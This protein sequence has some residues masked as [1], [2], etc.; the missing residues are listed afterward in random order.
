MWIYTLSPRKRL[1]RMRL[2]WFEMVSMDT[3]AME[4]INCRETVLLKWKHIK[5]GSV[6]ENRK[7]KL[8]D[9]ILKTDGAEMEDKRIYAYSAP[10]KKWKVL[11]YFIWSRK[12][13]RKQKICKKGK[14]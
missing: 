10:R 12:N 2:N 1:Y 13:E 8:G 7:I 3:K 9:G 4:D 11:N 14:N 5:G 6:K